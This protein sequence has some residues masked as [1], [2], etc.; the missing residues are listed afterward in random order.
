[1]PNAI[2]S[3]FVATNQKLRRN[4]EAKNQHDLIPYKA[5]QSTHQIG[6]AIWCKAQSHE[7]PFK[8]YSPNFN[9]HMT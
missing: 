8:L 1:M 4:E 6:L 7:L 9:K 2:S 3:T 5:Q